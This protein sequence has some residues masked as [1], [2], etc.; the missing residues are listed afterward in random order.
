MRSILGCLGAA[1]FFAASPLIYAAESRVPTEDG[2]QYGE[3]DGQPLTM[4]Y[5]APKGTGVHPIA[6]IIHGGGYQRGDSKS[7]S[8]AYCADF[9]APAGYAV[10]SIN[11]RLAPK[12]PYPYMVYDVERAVRYVRHNAAKWNADPNKIALVGLESATRTL[13]R[14][15]ALESKLTIPDQS[16][17]VGQHPATTA[18]AHL[19]EPDLGSRSPVRPV[20]TVRIAR[21]TDN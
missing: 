19:R 3:A 21:S 10:F 5:Y 6:I 9:L 14:R 16:R 7:G 1:V 20:A 11:Y 13:E 12:Y 17:Q 2:L 15:G 4:D 8:E 18:K